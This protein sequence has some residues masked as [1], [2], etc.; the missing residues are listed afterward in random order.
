MH[1]PAGENLHPAG[2]QHPYNEAD[3]HPYAIGI[4]AATS[5]ASGKSMLVA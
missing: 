5:A 1:M 4:D 2:T 3:N